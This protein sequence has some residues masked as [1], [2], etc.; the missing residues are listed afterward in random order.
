MSIHVNSRVLILIGKTIS[1]SRP[2]AH[3]YIGG[4]KVGDLRADLMT[5]WQADKYDSLLTLQ[6]DAAKNSLWRSN[7]VN[8]PRNCSS[9]TTQNKGKAPMPMPPYTRSH[10]NIG[11]SSHVSHNDFV[12]SG[13]KGASASKFNWGHPKDVNANFKSPLKSY[14]SNKKHKVRESRIMLKKL[15]LVEQG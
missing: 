5:N 14:N 12:G 13:S 7:A 15:R 8:I 1:P 4:L 2:L 6:N 11:Q 10:G 3:L 9:A